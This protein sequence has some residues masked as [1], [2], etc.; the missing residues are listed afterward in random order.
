MAITSLTQLIE[1]WACRSCL[2]YYLSWLY[3]RGMVRREVELAKITRADHVLVVGGGPCPH[4]AIQIHRLTG[5]RVTVVD[6]DFLCVRSAIRLLERLGIADMVQVLHRHGQNLK[7]DQYTVVVLALQLTP[8]LE[9]IRAME[10]QAKQGDRILIC[11]AK[12]SLA[13]WYSPLDQVQFVNLPAVT[14]NQFSN[15]KQT[16][17]YQVKEVESNESTQDKDSVSSNRLYPAHAFAG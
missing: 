8:K 17:L 12:D 16:V 6:N 5:A 4:T 3:Y 15:V 7:T 9:I 13:D 14:H 10:R 1:Y 11:L 2:F